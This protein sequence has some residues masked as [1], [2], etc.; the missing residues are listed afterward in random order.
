MKKFWKRVKA[1]CNRA[2]RYYVKGEYHC[3]HC[4]FSWEERSYDDVDC[5]CYIFSDL[6]GS[7]RLIPPVRFLLGWGKRRKQ[8]YWEAH[9]W[10]DAEQYYTE[11][12]L[13]YSR[14]EEGFDSVF[15]GYK[16]TLADENAPKPSSPED[17]ARM[18]EMLKDHC[19]EA[20]F[21]MAEY[22]FSETEPSLKDLWE[23]AFAETGRRLRNKVVPYLPKR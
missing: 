4:P 21:Q 6:Q 17:E 8:Q 1:S 3:D 11:Q 9:M 23:E 18:S 19:K 5:G 12:D 20:L 2:W 15:D 10:D 13:R 7:C 16:I 22:V 14:F